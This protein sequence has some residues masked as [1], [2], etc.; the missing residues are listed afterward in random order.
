MFWF[1]E[2]N[3]GGGGGASLVQ[4]AAGYLESIAR[5]FLR[6]RTDAGNT[7]TL[8]HNDTDAKIET[9]IGKLNLVAPDGVESTKVVGTS[10]VESPLIKGT[11]YIESPTLKATASVQSDKIESTT[12]M[13]ELT[14]ALGVR[15]AI[16]TTEPADGLL[17]NN[18][19][20]S[21]AD[22][23]R[24]WIKYKGDLGNIFKKCIV[25][26][27]IT[28][29]TSIA[30]LAIVA[31]INGQEIYDT[32]FEIWVKYNLVTAKWETNGVAIYEE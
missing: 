15:S 32:D 8:E 29:G 7:L 26:F 5:V 17:S 12:A 30:I 4:V 18:Q 23:G 6:V 19:K 27:D 3:S 1:F 9:N 13:L 31:P 20:C 28:S 2:N 14:G 25:N 11:G 10:S 21:Y 16:R 24:I 22:S